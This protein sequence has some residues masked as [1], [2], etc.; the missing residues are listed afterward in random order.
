MVAQHTAQENSMFGRPS[1][2]SWNCTH[3]MTT[4]GEIDGE[5][6]RHEQLK[7]HVERLLTMHAQESEAF[8]VVVKELLWT[9][10]T[11]GTQANVSD[12]SN[13]DGRAWWPRCFCEATLNS[14]TMSTCFL[15]CSSVQ[16]AE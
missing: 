13:I 14:M 12:R 6:G 10:Q 5:Q 11:Q 3:P 4:L 16:T 15:P 1:S 8:S 7:D 9:T 2:Y